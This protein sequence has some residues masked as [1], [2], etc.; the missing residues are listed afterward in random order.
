MA[1]GVQMTRSVMVALL[2]LV[3]VFAYVVLPV[4][5]EGYSVDPTFGGILVGLIG[6]ASAN[7]K[8]DGDAP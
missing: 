8:D 5:V 1:A 7:N 3:A 6:L 4:L 2:L